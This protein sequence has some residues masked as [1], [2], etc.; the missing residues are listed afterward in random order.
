MSAERFTITLPEGTG[1][2]LRKQAREKKR[3]VSRIVA[4]ALEAQEREQ[5]RQRMIEGYK[6][7]AALNRQLAEEALPAI[8]EVLPPD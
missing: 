5:I 8:R 3:P 1:K 2:W 6:E 4:D 7:C